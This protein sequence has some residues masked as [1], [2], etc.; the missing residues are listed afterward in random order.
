LWR[1]YWP[2]V[3]VLAAGLGVL[4]LRVALDRFQ[5]EP[6]NWSKI[7]DGLYLGGAVPKPPPGTQAVLNLCEREDDYQAD[8]QRWQPIK[9]GAPAPTLDWLREQVEF[10][11]TERDAGK[12]VYV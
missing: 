6:P 9:D 2:V 3:V 5:R 4:V 7:D 8:A 12:T 10:I 1:R 11:K